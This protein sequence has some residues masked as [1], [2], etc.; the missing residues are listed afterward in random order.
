MPNK[1]ILFLSVLILMLALLTS[2]VGCAGGGEIKIGAVMDVTGALSGMALDIRNGAVMAVNE[3]NRAGGIDGKELKLVVE[4]G[5]TESMIGF[6]A[7]KKLVEVTK[8]K[9]VIGPMIAGAI[10]AAGSYVGEKKVVL[11]SP[12]AVSPEIADQTWRQFVFR[13]AP[14]DNLQGVGISQLVVEG[15][16]QRVATIV[17]DNQ[18]GAGIEN[19]VKDMLDGKV[20]ILTSIRYN[21][22]KLDYLTELQLLKDENPDVVIHCGYADD[23]QTLYK[24]ALGLGLDKAQWITVEGVYSAKTLEVPEAAEFMSE[25]VIGIKPTASG[26]AYDKFVED[27]R[28]EFGHSPGVYAEYSY[29]AMKLAALAIEQAGYSDGAAISNALKEIGKGYSGISGTITFADNGDRLGGMY[30]VWKV[31][32]EDGQYKYQRVKDISL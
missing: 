31:V 18:Y 29:D 8:V 1:L 10:M 4:D 24:Q 30:E 22:A 27:F 23:A 13:T 2:S 16:Y 11:I 6:E 17:V 19:V 26:P 5:A 32:K 14:L 7:V 3:I 15:N 28:T 12:S 20:Q 21:P 9:V 25:A